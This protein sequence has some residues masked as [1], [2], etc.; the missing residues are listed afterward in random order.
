MLCMPFFYCVDVSCRVSQVVSH[1]VLFIVSSPAVSCLAVQHF[2]CCY[3][4]L[5]YIFVFVQIGRYVI[6]SFCSNT[7]LHMNFKQSTQ[8]DSC[9]FRTSM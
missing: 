5:C 2:A 8:F 7:D 1:R 3:V 9:I 6:L 4:M